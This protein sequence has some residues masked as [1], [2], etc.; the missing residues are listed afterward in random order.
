MDEQPLIDN[1]KT[2]HK[3]IIPSL[4]LSML[5][6]IGSIILAKL[7]YVN[8]C[9]ESRDT[10][11]LNSWIV[12]IS[13]VNTIVLGLVLLNYLI[14]SMNIYIVFKLAYGLFSVGN[15]II[16]IVVWIMSS[17]YCDFDIIL[18]VNMAVLLILKIIICLAVIYSIKENQ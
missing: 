18:C 11:F 4:I 14:C 2:S 16:G 15:I 6:F 10:L 17:K 1:N 3:W 7:Y 8:L 12:V 9:D 13:L 5:I